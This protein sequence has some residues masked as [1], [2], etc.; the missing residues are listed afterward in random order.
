MTVDGFK[1]MDIIV[2]IGRTEKYVVDAFTDDGMCCLSRMSE[3]GYLLPWGMAVSPD[4]P[5]WVKIGK[6]DREMNVEVEEI[7][8]DQ[9]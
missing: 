1:W 9:I 2:K 7:D 8:N 4:D 3:H 5:T 6:W